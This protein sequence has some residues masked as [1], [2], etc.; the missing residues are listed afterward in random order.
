MDIEGEKLLQ[1]IMTK[2]GFVLDFH[3]LLAEEDPQFLRCYE[4]MVSVAYA[5][6]R[7]LD[8]KTKELIFIGAL[9]SLEAEPAHIGAHMK[10]AM[11]HGASKREI[12]EVLECV[13][14]PCGTLR[15]MNGLKAFKQSVLN[16]EK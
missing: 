12:L 1:E 16:L 7:T 5:D 10:L 4:D 15:F 13:Y 9:M 8:K 11:E 14:P 3:R 6:R 2:R